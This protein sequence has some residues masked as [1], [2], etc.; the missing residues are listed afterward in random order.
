MDT[1]VIPSADTIR[2]RLGSLAKDRQQCILRTLPS[3]S[4]ISIA[5]ESSSQ[6]Q[7][8]S[9]SQKVEYEGYTVAGLWLDYLV[10]DGYAKLATIPS[11]EHPS[12]KRIIHEAR[13]APSPPVIPSADTTDARKMEW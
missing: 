8:I 13:S 11:F 5:L 9:L 3:G 6:A 4:K 12:F 2:R 1:P 10:G 7:W